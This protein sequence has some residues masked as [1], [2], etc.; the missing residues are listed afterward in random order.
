MRRGLAAIAASGLLLAGCSAGEP[1]PAP[2]TPTTPASESSEPSPAAAYGPALG[3]ALSE[4]V[5]DRVYPD[6]GD[7]GVDAL[8]YDLDLTWDP[9][10]SVLDGTELLTF[11]STQDSRNVRLDLAPSMDVSHVRIDGDGVAFEQ[12]GKDLVV[13]APVVLDRRY[14]VEIE[15]DGTPRPVAAPT[16]RRD[17]ALVGWTTMSDGSTWTMQEPFGAYSWYAVNDHPSDKAL[18]DFTLRVSA[19]MVGIANGELESR[20]R[21]DGQTVTKWHLAEPAASYL[22][23]VTFG[24][25]VTETDTSAGGVPV[26]IWMPRPL[27]SKTD[28]QLKIA[29]DSVE[30]AED[31]LGPYPFDTL[32]FLFVHS[33]S[34]METQT[35]ITLGL[36][37]YTT[38]QPVLVHEVVHQW[39][40]DQVT[41]RDW[42]DV[43][44]N[45]GMTMYLQAMWES[46][47]ADVPLEDRLADWAD[48][49]ADLRRKAGAPA[50]YDPTRFAEANVYYL[51]A[52]MWH[53][54]RERLGDDE[55]FRLVQEWPASRDNGHA[56]YDDITTWWEDESGVE[57]TAVFRKHLLAKQ[58]PA[59]K[60]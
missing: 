21:V 17:A 52:V 50:A 37:D 6:V 25:Y 9:E 34:G 60:P 14:V 12:H 46:E 49:G 38:S 1:T 8:H 45:E 18:Y 5:E 53:Q 44:M 59:Y 4:P 30:W 22:V 55:F 32:G 3:V 10:T 47:N 7:P 29:V 16:T 2:A 40:G 24:D 23:T 31:R 42:R 33:T 54:V 56:D 48:D 35:M 27:T 19:P 58:Q 20:H 28:A 51:P 15:Y 41:P 36:T 43:W 13:K 39:W 26:S 57:L 11:R